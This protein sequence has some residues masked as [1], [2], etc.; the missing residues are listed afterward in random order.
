MSTNILIGNTA[1][2]TAVDN[3]EWRIAYDCFNDCKAYLERYRPWDTDEIYL[4]K[5]TNTGFMSI[6]LKIYVKTEH[7]K[8][9]D[10]NL[11]MFLFLLLK[12]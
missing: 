1:G 5:R 3:G 8:I 12:I 9:Q 4:L 10:Q 7:L 6:S 11:R 2:Q